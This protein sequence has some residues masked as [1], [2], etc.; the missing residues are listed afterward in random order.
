[1]SNLQMTSKLYKNGHSELDNLDSKNSFLVNF[2]IQEINFEVSQIAQVLAKADTCILVI[3]VLAWL[4]NHKMS[5]CIHIVMPCLFVLKKV[6]NVKFS[7][8]MVFFGRV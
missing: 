5:A 6:Q 4:R 8:K 1:M 2:L 3:L 7:C